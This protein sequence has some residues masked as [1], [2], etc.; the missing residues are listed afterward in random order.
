MRVEVEVGRGIAY[1]HRN[2]IAYTS[3][4]LPV[5]VVVVVVV[6]VLCF[7]YFVWSLS[8]PK[9]VVPVYFLCEDTLK[10][11]YL[12]TSFVKPRNHKKP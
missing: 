10:R 6:V 8:N 2:R 11:S 9:G 4:M 3:T 1:T 5:V 12:S 7:C